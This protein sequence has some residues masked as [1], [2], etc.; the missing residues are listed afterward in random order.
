M[1]KKVKLLFYK[2]I[3]N[4]FFLFTVLFRMLKLKFCK[5]TNKDTQFVWDYFWNASNFY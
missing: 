4:Y 1:I 5:N 2:F 3:L